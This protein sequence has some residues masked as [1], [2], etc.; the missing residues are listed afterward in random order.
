MRDLGEDAGAEQGN[1]VQKAKTE[2][3]TITEIKA[4]GKS[5]SQEKSW[6]IQYEQKKKIKEL[7]IQSYCV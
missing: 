3:L 7:L 5:Q 2:R 6:G 1:Q 4:N